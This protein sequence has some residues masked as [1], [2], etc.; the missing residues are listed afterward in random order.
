[1]GTSP[2]PFNFHFF[3][4]ELFFSFFSFYVSRHLQ[5]LVK[6]KL[7]VVIYVLATAFTT[8]ASESYS[9]S[10]RDDPDVT[11]YDMVP[12]NSD[13]VDPN[14]SWRRFQLCP[15]DHYVQGF[16]SWQDASTDSKGLTRVDFSCSRKPRQ[17]R[18]TASG[19]LQSP[20]QWIG[21][22]VAEGTKMEARYCPNVLQFVVGVE[23]SFCG[24]S[25]GS[26]EI[27]LVCDVPNWDLTP[28]F[29]RGEA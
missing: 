19:K 23:L 8:E 24:S 10:V 28:Q 9:L 29:R 26:C 20:G 4:C 27:V 22:G 15:N 1:M 12:L 25:L 17:I 16:Q 2:L 13:L 21:S 3:P 5:S 14:A 6:M 7:I 18:I 11:T